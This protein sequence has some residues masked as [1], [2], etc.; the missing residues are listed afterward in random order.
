MDFCL[1]L[2]VAHRPTIAAKVHRTEGRFHTMNSLGMENWRWLQLFSS[3]NWAIAYINPPTQLCEMND[4]NNPFPMD[5]LS[6][7]WKFS[8]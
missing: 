5:G 6:K 8:L 7:S 2:Q 3:S 4:N 1:R